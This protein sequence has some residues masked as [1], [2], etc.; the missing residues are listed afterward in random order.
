MPKA[1]SNHAL[2]AVITV[3]SAF[4]KDKNYY[5]QM[6]IHWKMQTQCKFIQKDKKWLDM[7]KKDDLEI[8]SDD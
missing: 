2:L 1:D 5:S 7:T 3:D 4:K 8:Y 6:Q